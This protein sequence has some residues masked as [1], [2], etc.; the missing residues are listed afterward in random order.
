MKTSYAA[1]IAFSLATLAASHAM[2]M[3]SAPLTRE[4]VRAELVQAQLSGDIVAD[5]ERGLKLN[6]L[7][8]GNYPTKPASQGKTREQVRAE[9]TQAQVSGDIMA[10]SDRGKM[11]NDVTPGKY[12]AEPAQQGKNRE[13]V[14]AERGTAR[15]AAGE[16]GGRRKRR[17]YNARLRRDT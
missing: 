12:P 2:A 16:S 8:P 13:E 4:Q 14:L 9:L 17:L 7:H 6:E 15:K 10:G 5:G 1:T 11:L 3:S